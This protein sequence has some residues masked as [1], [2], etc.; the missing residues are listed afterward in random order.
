MFTALTTIQVWLQSLISIDRWGIMP[1]DSIAEGALV[2]RPP[3]SAFFETSKILEIYK[4]EGLVKTEIHLSVMYRFLFKTAYANLPIKE[5][6]ALQAYLQLAFMQSGGQGYQ[7]FSSVP[8]II[9]LL[10]ERVTGD[11]PDTIIKMPLCFGLVA[12]IEKPPDLIIQPPQPVWSL[13]R[14]D[15]AIWKQLIPGTP[16]DAAHSQKDT[17]LHIPR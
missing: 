11:T 8:G 16:L 5:L 3:T 7:T 9:E 10:K 12:A 15:V 17:M 2:L 4:Q 1:P 13:Q 14:I 6:S